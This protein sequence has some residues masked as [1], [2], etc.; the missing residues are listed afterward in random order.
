MNLN[1]A[2]QTTD[3]AGTRGGETESRAVVSGA[4]SGARL[5]RGGPITARQRLRSSGNALSP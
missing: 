2:V 1:P 3:L 5:R 4:L